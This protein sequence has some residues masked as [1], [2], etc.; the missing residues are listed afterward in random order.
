MEMGGVYVGGACVRVW[1]KEKQSKQQWKESH[2][3][4][5]ILSCWKRLQ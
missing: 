3:L 2:F 4:Y 1:V 5:T